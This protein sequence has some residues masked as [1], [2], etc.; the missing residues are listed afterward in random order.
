MILALRNSM[1]GLNAIQAR[2]DLL[3]NS[4]D[5]LQLASVRTE[6]RLE[7]MGK[8]ASVAP[9][10]TPSNANSIRDL[11][12]SRFDKLQNSLDSLLVA[13]ELAQSVDVSAG[14]L[15][16]L[17]HEP[18]HGA[19]RLAFLVHTLELRNHFGPVWDL[20]PP[21]SFDVVLHG[22]DEDEAR[23]A[24]SRWRCTVRRSQDVLDAGDVYAFLVSNHPV[25]ISEPPLIKRLATHNVRFLYAAGKSGWNLSA[26]NALYDV[27]LSFGPHHTQALSALSEATIVQMGY[28][29]FDRFFN[30]TVDRAQLMRQ[31]GCDSSRETV[32][33]LPTWKELS[34][35]GWFDAEISALT[36]TYNVVVKL[37]PLMTE[38]EPERVE[39]IRAYPFNCLITDS[40]D[41]LPLYQL[42]DYMLFDYGGPPMAALYADKKLLLLDV[43]DAQSDPLL[44]PDSPDL[45]ILQV[46]GS[47]PHGEGR[48]AGFLADPEFWQKQEAQRRQLRAPYFAPHY[49]FSADV[50]A[51]A[52]MRLES[53]VANK[54]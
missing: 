47:L 43:P 6:E 3:Q 54:P 34:S 2:F 46:L 15:A 22:P 4:L 41:N 7:Q 52:L 21:G 8:A 40:S 17:S 37:H 26:W 33:W 11:I 25:D 5:A 16:R 20:L 39:R 50:A 30:E 23:I 51:S 27:I 24:L 10:P 28:P 36:A 53:L 12:R 49:G 44:S 45:Q 14:V 9:E 1:S 13:G 32:V 18:V 38:Q 48:I 31:Y 19:L 29:R 42:A 35:V